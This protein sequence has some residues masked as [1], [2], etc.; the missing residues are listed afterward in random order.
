MLCQVPE[1]LRSAQ[2]EA[3]L[4]AIVCI[5][6]PWLG[7]ERMLWRVNATEMSVSRSRRGSACA[8]GS[9]IWGAA[10]ETSSSTRHGFSAFENRWLSGDWA[11]MGA[12]RRQ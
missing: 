6:T 11:Q 8:E 10:A 3:A 5:S 2:V 1:D 12:R 7:S 9:D 4:P